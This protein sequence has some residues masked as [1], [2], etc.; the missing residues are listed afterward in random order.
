MSDALE[1]IKHHKRPHVQPRDASIEPLSPATVQ[2][3]QIS[4][5]QDTQIPKLQDTNKPKT[6]DIQISR[7]QDTLTSETQTKQS[8]IRLEKGLSAR[9][10][11]KCREQGVSREV[12]IEALYQYFENHPEIHDDVLGEA[13]QRNE[14]RQQLANVK[15]AKS[16]M[17]RFGSA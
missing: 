2:D 6:Q 12:L 9:L 17:E 4:R 10:Q 14:Q 13:E 1:R 3:S 7:N 16:M 5:S 8:T 11:Q 15:R